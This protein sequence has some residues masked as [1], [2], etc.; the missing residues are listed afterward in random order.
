MPNYHDYP[1]AESLDG[2]CVVQPSQ[3]RPNKRLKSGNER[4]ENGLEGMCDIIPQVPNPPPKRSNNVER[5]A[6][7]EKGVGMNIDENADKNNPK[8]LQT[9]NDHNETEELSINALKKKILH[10]NQTMPEIQPELSG[11]LLRETV[12]KYLHNKFGIGLD[13]IETVL[14]YNGPKSMKMFRKY[15]RQLFDIDTINGEKENNVIADDTLKKP[16]I[17]RRLYENLALSYAEAMIDIEN[18]TSNDGQLMTTNT[19]IWG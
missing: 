8:I 2:M 7:C 12:E 3:A 4:D 17:S 19:F 5:S 18:N 13:L 10:G 1:I 15:L 9:N 16:S 11:V 14:Q 6:S